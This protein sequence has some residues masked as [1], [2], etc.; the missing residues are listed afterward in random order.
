MD[1]TEQTVSALVSSLASL[2]RLLARRSRE[3]QDTRTDVLRVDDRLRLIETRPDDVTPEHRAHGGG[4]SLRIEGSLHAR[5]RGDAS[6]TW[7]FC[8]ER[9]TDGSW[10]VHRGLDVGEDTVTELSPARFP[11]TPDFA[12]AMP[13]LV[14]ELLDLEPPQ[15]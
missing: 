10:V 8:F 6:T 11:T 12:E 9:V 4:P 14:S 7:W 13:P 15:T 5:Q 3:L 1:Q 2:T